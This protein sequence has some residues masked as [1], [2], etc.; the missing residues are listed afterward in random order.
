MRPH[1]A[2]AHVLR[3]RR[4]RRLHGDEREQLQKVVLQK[5][6]KCILGRCAEGFEVERGGVPEDRG[7]DPAANISTSTFYGTRLHHVADDPV[8]VEVAPSPQRPD[9]LLER[10]PHT[11]HL[12]TGARHLP[13]LS[14]PVSLWVDPSTG[15]GKH[16]VG[17]V[18]RTSPVLS[19][20][21]SSLRPNGRSGRGPNVRAVP[22]RLED[23]V[24]E[25]QRHE[26]LRPGARVQL[27]SQVIDK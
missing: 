12:P 19:N 13:A 27:R 24:G 4:D 25:A 16:S 8:L 7:D 5:R 22:Q 10:D 15:E 20:G 23:Q 17:H 18:E 11:R 26:R 6:E 14:S 3:I 21:D 1:L 9:V 2:V